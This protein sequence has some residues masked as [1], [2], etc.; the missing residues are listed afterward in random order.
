MFTLKTL[1][2]VAA[3]AVLSSAAPAN[4]PDAAS[5]LTARQVGGTSYASVLA[6]EHP[7]FTGA[8]IVF[9]A[10]DNACSKCQQPI[11]ATT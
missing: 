1:I 9:G 5:A 4:S 7:Q 8:C 11:Q 3:M 10:T 6:C 2:A